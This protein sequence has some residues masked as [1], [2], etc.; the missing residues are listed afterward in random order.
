[1]PCAK[2]WVSGDHAWRCKTC[3]LDPSCAICL[4]CFRLSDH[5]GHE[6]MMISTAN[7]C[8][9]CGDLEAWREEG[10]CTEHSASRPRADNG[11]RG[12]V[13]PLP[14]AMRPTAYGVVHALVT[15]WALALQELEQ[16]RLS[17]LMPCSTFLP[18]ARRRQCR[19]TQRTASHGF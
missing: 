2:R 17:G 14:P 7:G 15:E 13:R 16:V 3:E 9:D 8:C 18:L 4:D 1:M 5:D 11:D 10:C 12:V 6:V 19:I